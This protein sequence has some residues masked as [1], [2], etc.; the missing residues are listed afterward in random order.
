MADINL[1]QVRTE[2]RFDFKLL[3]EDDGKSDFEDNDS[4]YTTITA[5][6]DFYKPEEFNQKARNFQSI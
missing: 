1:D 2:P 5:E 3:Y 6:C 4:P